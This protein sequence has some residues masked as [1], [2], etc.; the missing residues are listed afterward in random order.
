MASIKK[1][2][3]GVWRARYRD[4]DGKEHASHFPTKTKAQTW[5]DE[6]TASIVIGAYVDPAGAKTLFDAWA[7]RVFDSTV[8]LRPSTRARDASYY[9]N[10]VKPM[11]GMKRLGALDHLTVREWIAELSA[12]GLAPATVQ[13]CHQ[14]LAKIMRAAVDAGLIASSPCERQPLPKVEREEMRFLGPDE[15]ATLADAIDERYRA[16]VLVGAYGG[17]RAGELFGLRRGRVDLLRG[18]V[19]VAETLVEVGG[20]HHFGPPK[21]RAGR[22]SVPLPRFVV[23]VL[24]EHV[25]GLEP[26]ELVFPAPEGGP[27]RSSL[28]RRRFWYPASVAAGLGAS[29]KDAETGK[30]H[31]TGLRLHDL[32]HSAVSLW[33]AAGASG[34]EVA[35]RA[36]HT[37]VSVVLDRYG[38]LLP[39]TEERV[40]DALDAMATKAAGGTRGA[41]VTALR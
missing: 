10:H 40:T 39:G 23:D 13:K 4:P 20:H 16:L 15:I 14:V 25:A 12:S 37:S 8:D 11:F 19:D 17:L 33:I 35:V 36:G 28:F 26:G 31:Y 24:T 22:R 2:E 9:K 29:V 5:L 27:V 7:E 32:R 21:T 41:R 30:E 38:H 3:D 18:R 34:K 1:R 6:K